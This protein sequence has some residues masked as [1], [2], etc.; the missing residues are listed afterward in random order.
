MG[1]PVSGGRFLTGLEQ[2]PFSGSLVTWLSTP[3]LTGSDQILM[4]DASLGPKRMHTFHYHPQQEE[5]LYILEG[6]VEQWLG[7]EMRVLGPGEGVFIPR[8][9]V[10]AAANVTSEPARVIAVTSPPV[11]PTGHEMV[12]VRDEEPWAARMA[13]YDAVF[14]A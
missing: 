4:L 13:A 1:G 6:S 7:D 9:V 2:V 11:G 8:G 5:I 14:G 12:D 3:E 10:H